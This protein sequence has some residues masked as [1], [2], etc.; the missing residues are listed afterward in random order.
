M[1]VQQAGYFQY[2]SSAE[3]AALIKGADISTA[4]A[5]YPVNWT[6]MAVQGDYVHLKCGGQFVSN[7]T[8]RY[9]RV[10]MNGNSVNARATFNELKVYDSSQ[11]ERATGK[12]VTASQVPLAGLLSTFTDGDYATYTVV[13]D[14]YQW[15]KVD[16]AASYS[17]NWVLLQLYYADARINHNVMI[18]YSTDNVNWTTLFTSALVIEKAEKLYGRIIYRY[19]GMSKDTNFTS[20][21]IVAAR[22]AGLKVGAYWFHNPNYYSTTSGWLSTIA[23]AELEATQFYDYIRAETSNTDMLDI[24]PMFDLENQNGN[25]YPALTND[26]AFDFTQAFVAKFKALTGRQCTLYTAYYTIDSLTNTPNNE[27]FHSTKGGIGAVCPLTLAATDTGSYP[28]YSYTHFGVFANNKWTNWQFSSDG[29]AQGS[30]WGVSSSDVDLDVLDGAIYTI[31]PPYVPTGLTTTAGDTQVVLNWSAATDDRL[32]TNIYKNG[33]YVDFVPVATLTFT[34]T[35]LTNGVT[36]DFQISGTDKWEAGAKTAIVTGTP[37]V[38]GASTVLLA[39]VTSESFASG[40]FLKA[41]ATGLAVAQTDMFEFAN[42]LY[43]LNGAE[44]LYYEIGSTVKTVEGYIPKVAIATPPAGGVGT[45]E[46]DGLGRLFEQLNVLTGKKRQTFSPNG[47]AADFY[48]LEQNVTSIDKVYKNGILLTLTTDYT[49][50]L[51]T[52]MVHFVVVP[53]TGNPS[54]IEIYWTKGLGQ[55]S[56]IEACR[57]EM[58][59]SGQTDSRVFLWGNIALKNR[60]FW[61]GLADGVPSAEYFEANSFDD[62][63]TGEFAITDIIKQYDRQKIFFELNGGAMYS[64]YSATTDLVGNTVVSFPTFELNET[65]S[66]QAFHQVRVINNNPYTLNRGVYSWKGSNVRDQSN[67][68]LISKRVKASLD[69]VDLSTAKTY[70]WQ[71]QKEYW[72]NVGSKVW[73]HNYL[74]NTWYNFDNIAAT[75]FYVINGEMYFGKADGT[76]QKFETDIRND[77]GAAIFVNWEMAFYDFGADWRLKYINRAWIAINSS[78][79]SSLDVAY[80]TNVDNGILNANQTISFNVLNFKHINFNHF[81]FQTTY[82]PQPFPIVIDVQRFVYFKFIL[83]KNDPETTVTVISINMQGRLGGKL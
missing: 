45:V 6:T 35:G 52:G 22:A 20:A 65:I 48:I 9:I 5:Q 33:V 12:T 61:S 37:L 62:L 21:N 38:G 66:N 47:T 19:G 70:D 73:V 46:G 29:N 14:G 31:M 54:N 57:F 68:V 27:L 63:G 7:F 8:A 32:Y 23:Q 83:T 72:L 51:T 64:Y 58:E 30:T 55:R 26:E 76:I 34:V 15:V 82:N 59:F 41:L 80:V 77:N 42:K 18:E 10:S 79:R 3:R 17:I 43:I 39:S 53:A 78:Y 81:S 44:Y 24:M 67:A 49:V 13:G 36:Y 50:N 1:T 2:Y 28:A 75:I 11:T 74:T 40:N 71:E 60:R 25:I 16:L 4:G 69:T 56:L